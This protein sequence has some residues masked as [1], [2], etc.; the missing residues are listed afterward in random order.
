MLSQSETRA[1]GI[2]ILE[3]ASHCPAAYFQPKPVSSSEMDRFSAILQPNH[4]TK[5]NGKTGRVSPN[6]ESGRRD[7][8]AALAV[9]TRFSSHHEALLPIELLDPPEN[10]IF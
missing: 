4:A 9:P 6:G 2:Q 5:V 3:H 10:L 8:V 7:H 1:S